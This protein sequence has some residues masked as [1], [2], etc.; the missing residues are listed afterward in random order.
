[1]S[2]VIKPISQKR[3]R[4][5]LFI[6]L[7]IYPLM[8]MGIDLIAPSLPA[9]TQDLNIS[10]IISKNL[11]S[12]YLLGYVFGNFFTGFLSDA[13]GRRKFIIF[14]FLLFS[15]SSFLPQLMYS[16]TAL[17]IIRFLQG[18]SL[19]VVGIGASAIISDVL[20]DKK[21]LIQFS[22]IRAT[23]WGIG[24]IIG[25]IIGGYLQHYFNWQACF[26]FF[27]V[28]GLCCLIAITI[29]IPETHRNRQMI[30]LSVIKDNFKVVVNHRLFMG[31][32]FLMGT[33]YSLLIV[34]NTLGPF[35]IQDHLGYTPIF[36][37]QMALC[38][39]VVFLLGTMTCRHLTKKFQAE[40]IIIYTIP[41]ILLTATL[42]VIASFV[43][44][45]NIVF[46]MANSFFM[47]FGCGIIYPACMGK[48]LALFRHLAG[49]SAAVM[50]LVNIFV[51]SIAAFLASLV[52]TSNLSCLAVSYFILMA[53]CGIC[54]MVKVYPKTAT[55]DQI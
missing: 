29:V 28:Y 41:L 3:E 53:L 45:V 12:I 39:G 44:E 30:N 42:G 47:F 16:S 55:L 38:L 6:V 18:L 24:P 52:N 40:Q 1:M 43:I 5:I 51:T 20:S 48:A 2:T 14:G 4:L 31:L 36:F 7:C 13:L 21:K 35:L 33:Q 17:L 27:A 32:V 19:G 10:S 15:A 25:P 46:I 26:N 23:M 8:G 54:F 49:S 11:F 37:G 50:N 34:F 22:V 9:I